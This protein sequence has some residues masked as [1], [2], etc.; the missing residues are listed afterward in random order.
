MATY[1]VIV[2]GA[3][4]NGLTTAAYLAKA[5][6]KVLVLEKRDV[7]GGVAATEEVFSGFKVDT[8]SQNI[9]LRSEVIGDLEL[10]RHGLETLG[11]EPTLV[12]L[13]S[14]GNHLVLSGNAARS[15]EAIRKFSKADADK[16]ESFN[17]LITHLTRFLSDVYAVTPPRITELNAD[18]LLTLGKLGLK[19]RGLGDKDMIEALRLLPMALSDFLGDWFESDALKGALASTGITGLFQPPRASGTTYM[20]LHHLV[21]VNGVI[22]STVTARGG[23]G[24]LSTALAAAA[25]SHGAEIRTH[26]E[27]SQIVVKDGKAVGV[28]LADGTELNASAIA[29]GLDPKHTML[30][31]VDPLELDPHFVRQIRNIKFKGVVARVN[32]ALGELPNFG[33]PSLLRG[34][35]IVVAPN[36]D[37]LERAY[38][39]AKYGGMSHH[40]YLRVVVPSVND[41]SLAPAGKQVM[42]VWMQYAPYRLRNGNWDDLRGSVGDLVVETLSQFAPNLKSA[43]LHRQVITPLDL[44]QTYGVTEGNPYHGELTLDQFFFMRPVAGWAQYRTP[45]PGLYLCGAGTHPGGGVTGAAG[46]NAARVILQK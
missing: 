12:S 2:I 20:M 35:L 42:T 4:H 15:V 44:E 31:L 24:A 32:L 40:P 3:G 7:L 36:M 23:V 26:A 30:G 46:R 43:I 1:D 17:A 27:V 19:L 39:D 6:R 38:D 29:S 11:G 10:S 13:Q 34:A 37:Y 9:N 21:G 8:V 45:I 14:A 18:T 41:P 5:G 33:D 28:A 16:Y 25:K 22:P